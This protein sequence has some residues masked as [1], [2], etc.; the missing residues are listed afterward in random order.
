MSRLLSL[1]LLVGT[2]GFLFGIFFPLAADT[3][4]APISV[5]TQRFTTPSQ[6][7]PAAPAVSFADL[8]DANEPH[9]TVRSKRHTASDETVTRVLTQLSEDLTESKKK[10][11]LLI[12]PTPIPLNMGVSPTPYM[13]IPTM[14]AAVS[15][16]SAISPQLADRKPLN[17]GELEDSPTKDQI[18]IGILGD[19]MVETL[20]KNLPNLSTLLSSSYPSKSFL[21]LN[22]GQPSTDLETAIKRLTESAVI[23]GA[24]SPSLL[25]YKPTIIVLESFAYNHWTGSLSDLDRQW[26]TIAHAIDAIKKYSPDT[27]IV[28]AATVAP[29]ANTFGDGVLN[30]S[31][32]KKWDHAQVT[33][34]YLQN[35]IR[36]A[37]SEHYPVADAYHPSLAPDGN[38]KAEYINASDHIHPSEEGKKL[39]SR[40]LFETMQRE[41]M[42]L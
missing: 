37:T 39:F 7:S 19:S 1:T 31:K 15:E 35:V 38:G 3:V 26:I 22:Y 23:N 25:S 20:G 33:K 30:W 12:S 41:H 40:I 34:A 32:Q 27:K 14:I 28:L 18:T 17:L 4:L 29:D 6:P 2:T 16:L 10:L 5:L 36:F 11:A 24:Y 21:L 9:E 13:P 8:Q 42:I